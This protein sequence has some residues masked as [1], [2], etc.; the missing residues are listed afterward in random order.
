MHPVIPGY[1]VIL[2]FGM[3][4]REYAGDMPAKLGGWRHDRDARGNR[5][6][7]EVGGADEISS[8]GGDQGRAGNRHLKQKKTPPQRPPRALRRGYDVP[9]RMNCEKSAS[10]C[11]PLKLEWMNQDFALTK[12]PRHSANGMPALWGC[13]WERVAI[14]ETWQ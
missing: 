10:D 5:A 9:P 2:W 8:R 3:K 4:T 11:P 1:G 7:R 6:A 14:S 12:K 13:C